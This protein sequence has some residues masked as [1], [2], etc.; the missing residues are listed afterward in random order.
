MTTKPQSLTAH[1]AR[2][3]NA[4]ANQPV[5]L[6]GDMLSDLTDAFEYYEKNE[7][8][9]VITI[10]HFK[11]ILTNFGFTK[12]NKREIDLELTKIYPEYTKATGVDFPFVKFVV[13]KHWNQGGGAL[14]EAQDCF[15]LLQNKARNSEFLEIED[16]KKGLEEYLEI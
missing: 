2:L 16:I 1:V 13:A 14:E 8:C 6:P 10:E 15:K 5:N 3:D 7:S 11:N 9:G 12:T 4:K